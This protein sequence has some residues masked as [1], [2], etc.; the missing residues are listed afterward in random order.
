MKQA[1]DILK[2]IQETEK[3][4]KTLDVN[5]QAKLDHIQAKGILVNS[6]TVIRERFDYLG[7]QQPDLADF[8]PERI[9]GNNDFLPV[10]F[11]EY[12]A[13]LSKT[14]GRV[15][16]KNRENGPVLE[17]GTGFLVGPTLMLTNQH[18][19][20][21]ARQA[22]YSRLELNYE[23]DLDGTT[24]PSY[25]FRLEPDKVF[26]SSDSD[27]LDY[28]L[29]SV[30]P[31]DVKGNKKLSD[32]GH[33]TLIEEVGKVI[34]GERLTIIQHPKGDPKQVALRDNKLV[35]KDDNFLHYTTDTAPGSSGAMVLNDQWE[36]V[37]LHRSGVPNRNDKNEIL[38]R[39]GKV[40]N[41]TT[42]FES[43][44][45]WIANEGVRISC[46]VKDIEAQSPG[47]LG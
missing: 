33:V 27:K 29:V 4:F 38:K 25:Q 39:D 20:E 32:F 28:A 42:D 46:I 36:V 7:Q 1:L 47:V 19:L 17:Y 30:T 8:I 9:L 3:R 6:P 15:L 26:I 21:N 11:F 16:V 35:Y 5:V 44:I 23:I 14:V 43:D 2:L 10:N 34:V 12:G 41:Y 31:V 13:K 37:A 18:V 45:D 22:K 40:W 24:K